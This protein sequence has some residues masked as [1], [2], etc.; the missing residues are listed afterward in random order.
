MRTSEPKMILRAAL[1]AACFDAS[2][3]VSSSKTVKGWLKLSN[4]NLIYKQSK[5]K[6]RVI[7]YNSEG[8]L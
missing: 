6:E 8:Q 7:W 3:I 5:I 1:S 2:A 4:T